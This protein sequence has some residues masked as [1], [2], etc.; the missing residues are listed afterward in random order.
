M[1]SQLLQK[2][3]LK[4]KQEIDVLQ[5]DIKNLRDEVNKLTQKFKSL[6]DQQQK[7]LQNYAPPRLLAEFENALTKVDDQ[8]SDLR[9]KF[10]EKEMTELQFVKAYTELRMLYHMLGTKKEKFAAFYG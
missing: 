4:K 6:K 3:N 9:K 10:Q 8:S 1:D 5:T 7:L 2:S